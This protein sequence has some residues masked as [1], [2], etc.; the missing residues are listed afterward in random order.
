MLRQQVLATACLLW[1]VAVPLA[2]AHYLWVSIGSKKADQN[3]ADQNQADQNQADQGTVQ[4][5]FEETPRPGDGFY[6]DPFVAGCQTW[7]RGLNSQEI[8]PVKL[9]EVKEGDL[10]W[11]A[12][13][14][15]VESPRSVESYGKFGVYRYGK[16]DA[17]LYYYAKTL[18]VAKSDQ[19]QKLSKSPKLDLDLVPL[20]VGDQL[21]LTVL[22]KGQ[23]VSDVQVHVVGPK[24]RQKLSTNTSGQVQWEAVSGTRYFVRATLIDQ[25][26]AGV[27]GGK[28]YQQV[29][30]SATLI[31]RTPTK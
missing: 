26:S 1:A 7:V 8:Q 28:E 20:P 21:Q 16:V 18:Q 24:Q 25:D 15:K 23:P 11:L 10:R 12:G 13:P 2:Q 5:V 14:L 4:V 22:W 6:L 9:S 29:R 27:E 3:Q 17:L 30:H 31:M 19:M